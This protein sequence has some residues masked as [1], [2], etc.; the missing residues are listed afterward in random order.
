MKITDD[1]TCY[2]CGKKAVSSEHV[3]PKCFFPK[4]KRT[5]LIQVPACS[6][7]NEDTSKDD[8]YVLFI[9]ASHVGNNEVGKKHSVEKGMKPLERSEALMSVIKENSVDVY[10]GDGCKLERSKMIQVDRE[11]FDKEITK[12]AYALYYKTYN[13][14]WNKELI[15]GTN[16]M[17]CGDGKI[18]DLGQ[19]INCAKECMKANHID[20]GSP[21]QGDNQEVFKYRFFETEKQDG[22]ILQMIFYEGFEVWAFVKL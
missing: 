12:M 10:V 11:R 6:E 9:I 13:K 2:Y 17:L 4:D 3:P 1:M 20:E 22:P 18:E 7:H 19:L 5:N 15:I 21:F 16:S 14:Q 8:S